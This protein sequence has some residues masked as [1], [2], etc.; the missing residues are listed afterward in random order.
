[1]PKWKV[2]EKKTATIMQHETEY[3]YGK[4]IEDTITYRNV[5]IKVISENENEYILSVINENIAL[6]SAVNFYEKMGEELSKYKNLELKYKI[7]KKTG[8]AEL[9]NWKESQKF[10]DESFAQI[11]KLIEKKVPEMASFAKLAF[12]PIEGI[13][14]SKKNIE[15]YMNGEIGY[16]LFPYDKKFVIGDTLKISESTQNPFNPKDSISQTTLAYLNNINDAKKV[17]DINTTDILDLA[18]FKKMM[19]TMIEKMAKSFGAEESSQA[20]TKEIDDIDFNITNLSVI[21][22]DYNKTWPLKV[23]KTGK[24]IAT[25]P[26]GKTE[27]TVVSTIEFK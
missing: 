23:V 24:V 17:C 21:T 9:I 11:T 26:K 3:K 27:K 1:M 4:L 16:L 2:G 25:T 5:E 20:K 12:V 8:K 10:M 13:F 18:E 22:F 6:R 19:K 14:K 7:N 15:S